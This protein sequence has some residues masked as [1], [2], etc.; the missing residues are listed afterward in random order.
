MNLYQL[1][2]KS[3]KEEEQISLVLKAFF[4]IAITFIARLGINTPG[5]AFPFLFIVL[6]SLI[7]GI[8]AI[9]NKWIW[10]AI[11]IVLLTNVVESFYSPANHHFLLM[12]ASLMLFHVLWKEPEQQR[13]MLVDNA[14]WLLIIV[15]FFV[16]FQKLLAPSYMNGEFFSYM[17]M[18][19]Q[20]F[21]P[22]P[23]LHPEYAQWSQQN[24]DL[25]YELRKVI[26]GDQSCLDIS[27]K[28]KEIFKIAG[29]ALSYFVLFIETL[30]F[31][32]V[33]FSKNQKVV[34]F[35]LLGLVVCILL[36]RPECGFLSILCG[37]GL[38][39]CPPELPRYRLAYLFFILLFTTLIMMQLVYY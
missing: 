2:I 9:H 19:G 18:R 30:V 15:L 36:A 27:V 37:L 39:T 35:S 3:L 26:P 31:F 8:K 5:I 12:F 1:I 16:S 11:F 24:L 25:Y 32:L 21:I 20:F 13:Q 29:K 7:V 38:A 14:K 22:I 6:S 23:V 33:A 28:H 34:H 10:L 17:L 4:L